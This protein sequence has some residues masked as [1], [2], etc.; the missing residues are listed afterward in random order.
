MTGGWMRIIDIWSVVV[1]GHKLK[2][3][4][5]S[6]SVVAFSLFLLLFPPNL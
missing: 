1:D 5:V 2:A 4:A 3:G 6:K